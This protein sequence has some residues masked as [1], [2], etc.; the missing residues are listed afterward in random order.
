MCKFTW[1]Q[2]VVIDIGQ[3]FTWIPEVDVDEDKH[4]HAICLPQLIAFA[5]NM[6][7][8]RHTNFD[9][10]SKYFTTMCTLLFLILLWSDFMKV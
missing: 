10:Y 6:M 3:I 1:S 4:M 5:M 7:K 8:Y 9:V 2:Y